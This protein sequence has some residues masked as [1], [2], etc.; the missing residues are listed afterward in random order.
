MTFKKIIDYNIP[1]HII[2]KSLDSHTKIDDNKV[3]S[4]EIDAAIDRGV[5][6]F[7]YLA[8]L[9]KEM[10]PKLQ[11]LTF[12]QNYSYNEEHEDDHEWW[13]NNF[14]QFIGILKLSYLKI[15]DSQSDIFNYF[16]W[17]QILDVMPDGSKYIIN[18][19]ASGEF[20][21]YPNYCCCLANDRNETKYDICPNTKIYNK[22]N[23]T[24]IVHLDQ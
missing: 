4:L 21:N 5:Q 16:N 12:Q 14:I 1:W 23:S 10:Y 24:L 19:Q 17:D 2:K 8:N 22:N 9:L 6:D 3:I 15:N 20:D 18:R 13:N 11:Q 7:E